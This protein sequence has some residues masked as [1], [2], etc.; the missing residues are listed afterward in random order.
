MQQVQDF[1]LKQLAYRARTGKLEGV[2]LDE[3]ELV[4]SPLQS[5]V[6]AVANNLKWEIN[7]LLP[8]IRI[9]DLLAEVN[10]WTEFPHILHICE[11]AN[12]PDQRQ[13]SCQPFLLMAPILGL[14]AWPIYQ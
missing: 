1:R 12:R 5:G 9:T 10:S 3:G 6:P 13:P 4:T 7:Q 14:N 2:R 11:H 8:R